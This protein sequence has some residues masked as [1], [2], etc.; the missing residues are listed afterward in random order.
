MIIQGIFVYK[1]L[2]L[3]FSLRYISAFKNIKVKRTKGKKHQ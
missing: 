2:M 3:H 1:I